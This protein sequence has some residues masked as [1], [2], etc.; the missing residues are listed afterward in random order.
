MVSLLVLAVLC[1]ATG[2]LGSSYP[3]EVIE[4]TDANFEHDTQAA[5][6]QTTGVWAVLFTDSTLK[7]HE[8]AVQVL[9]E[10]AAD[11]EKELIYAQ[12]RA[13]RSG[14]SGDF[15]NPTTRRTRPF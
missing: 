12:V 11:D 2:V 5:S 13:R 1:T 10:L 9:K 4:L 7:R 3:T 8:R 15:P 14:S 6:G